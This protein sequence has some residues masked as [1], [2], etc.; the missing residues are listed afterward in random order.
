MGFGLMG[1]GSPRSLST[2]G[3]VIVVTATIPHAVTGTGIGG[4]CVS[5][6]LS[7]HVVEYTHLLLHSQ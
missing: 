7:S 5:R 2:P 1:G 4:V 3:D 6:F